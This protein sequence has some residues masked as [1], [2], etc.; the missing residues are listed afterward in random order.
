VLGLVGGLL[1]VAGAA[2]PPVTITGG[3][4]RSNSQF[5]RWNITNNHT[6]PIVFIDFP[7]YHADT[8]TSPPG[9]NQEW[10]NRSMAGSKDAPGW[11]QTSVEATA[12]GVQP[13]ATAE[14]E[15]RLARAGADPRP[16]RVAV[17]FADG[18]ET[19]IGGVILPTAKPFLERNVM[20]IGLG[21]IFVIAVLIHLRHRR[22]PSPAAPSPSV[23]NDAD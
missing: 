3:V 12:Q 18:T 5:Y 22:Q 10:E 21:T 14:F 11:V 4:D 8:F 15:M 23:E 2:A 9:W 13:G 1:P 16:G 20:A 19:T 7:H 6:S 17:R